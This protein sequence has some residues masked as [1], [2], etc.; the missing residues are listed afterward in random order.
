MKLG[1]L[2]NPQGT[3]TPRGGTEQSPPLGG[4][5]LS[6]PLW[7]ASALLRKHIRTNKKSYTRLDFKP[8]AVFLD[9]NEV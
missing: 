9:G 3:Y 5:I 1:A 8:K 6:T 4:T 7:G 2:I